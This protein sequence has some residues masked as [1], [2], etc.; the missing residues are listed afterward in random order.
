MWRSVC[1]VSLPDQRAAPAWRRVAWRHAVL[2]LMGIS[3]AIILI[4]SIRFRIFMRV[5][6]KYQGLNCDIAESWHMIVLKLQSHGHT[7]ELKL[8]NNLTKYTQNI[9]HHFS[10]YL[11]RCK[12]ADG[13]G[14]CSPGWRH[15]P[16]QSAHKFAKNIPKNT[17]ILPQFHWF[18]WRAWSTLGESHSMAKVMCSTPT[19]P[20]TAQYHWQF[21]Y[22]IGWLVNHLIVWFSNH[23]GSWLCKT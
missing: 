7:T 17:G 18:F 10:D 2:L 8:Q 14:T 5:K 20:F 4:F 13:K 3:H 11:W 16:S 15:H 19:A 21:N 6:L 1:I 23:S 22:S 12:G 9:T